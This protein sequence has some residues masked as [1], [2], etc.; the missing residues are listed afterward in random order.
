MIDNFKLFQIHEDE[1]EE[2]ASKCPVCCECGETITDD[3]YYMFDGE[4]YCEGC[5]EGHRFTVCD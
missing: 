1:Q 5:L 2:K 4:I 3:F